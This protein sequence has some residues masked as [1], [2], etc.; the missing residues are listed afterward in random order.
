MQNCAGA[1][2]EPCD[3]KHDQADHCAPL[4]KVPKR[5]LCPAASTVRLAGVDIVG[6]HHVVI[7]L[8]MEESTIADFV[9]DPNRSTIISP[10]INEALVA[11]HA[12]PTK[13]ND[14][15]A[16]ERCPNG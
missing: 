1:G 5:L 16:L 14:V 11:L 15:S 10:I 6:D 4:L 2:Q 8:Y 9:R 13:S 7:I 12:M 3:D